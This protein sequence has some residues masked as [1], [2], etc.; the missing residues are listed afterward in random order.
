MPSNT[1]VGIGILVAAV[2]LGILADQLLVVRP[3]GVNVIIV[4]AAI[5][6]TVLILK[7]RYHVELNG[8]GRWLFVPALACEC[9]NDKRRD[10]LQ[11]VKQ[12]LVV[13]VWI[14]HF[15]FLPVPSWLRT[16]P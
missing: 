16:R 13:V 11:P 4:A 14:R 12:G 7:L 9:V 5:G 10:L 2:L 6:L 15:P 3:W 1:K 8:G